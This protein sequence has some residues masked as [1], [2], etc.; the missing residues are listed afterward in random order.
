[1]NRIKFRELPVG[2]KANFEFLQERG[3]IHQVRLCGKGHP[4]SLDLN[5][6]R[7]RCRKRECNQ[8]I[9]VRVGSWLEGTKL[10]FQ[11]IVEFIYAWTHEWSSHKWCF[12]QLGMQDQ[13]VVEWN[14]K[15]RKVCEEKQTRSPVLI[16]GR[17]FHVQ[18]DETLWSKRKNNAG[19]VLPQ[20][21]LLGGICEETNDVFIVTV[22]NR[23]RL[24]LFKE[25]RKHLKPGTTIVTDSWRAYQGLQNEGFVHLT[26]NHR[27]NFV[28]P[29]T[30]AHTQKVERLWRSLKWPNKRR[31]GTKRE[32]VDSYLSEFIW[33]KNIKGDDP[34]ISMLDDIAA[35][36]EL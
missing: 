13:Q 17:G 34:F 23:S 24:S 32:F 27:Y 22:L 11:C 26:V 6:L 2:E 21:W 16:G 29:T 1:M 9:G 5:R 15:M 19:R 7:W 30:G 14:Q 31:S 8:D 3:I 12:E 36:Y 20:L 10:S 35:I 33:F 25:I 28:D 4:M 18:V